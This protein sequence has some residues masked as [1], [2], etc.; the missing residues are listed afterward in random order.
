METKTFQQKLREGERLS[1]THLQMAVPE[2]A[3]IFALA[4]FDYV[5]IDTEHSPIDDRT[6]LQCI[7]LVRTRGTAAIVRVPV[8][9]YNR[10]KRVIEMGPDGI[11]FPMINTRALAEDAIRSTLYP[12]YGTRGFGPMRAVEYGNLEAR[13]YV[14][15]GVFGMARILQVETEEAVRNLKEILQVPYIDGFVI[16]PC[17]LAASVGEL[18]KEE[19]PK[20][21]ALIRKAAEILREAGKP[22]GVSFGEISDE[23][24]DFYLKIGATFASSGVDYGYLLHGAKE[25]RIRLKSAMKKA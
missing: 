23:T 18:C 5:W 4:G 12:P 2:H 21:N 16:G 14:E 13:D 9:D 7:N 24:L 8:H 19:Q 22:F 25:T 20:T 3:E 10:T 15:H 11:V 17:D 1:G 6:L